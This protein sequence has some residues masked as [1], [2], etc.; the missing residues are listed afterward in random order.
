MPRLSTHKITVEL[1]PTGARISVTG[2]EA[3]MLKN[4]LDVGDK[5]LTSIERPAPRISSYVAHLREAG[6][7]ISTDMEEHSGPYP[8]RHGR[9]RL[10]SRVQ[11]VSI[12]GLA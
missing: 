7:N 4:L 11:V 10:Q 2:R 12:E 9:Y 6:L 3:W 5:G 8:G 1:E